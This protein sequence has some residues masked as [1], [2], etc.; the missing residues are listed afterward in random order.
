MKQNIFLNFTILSSWNRVPLL[1]RTILTGILVSGIGVSIWSAVLLLVLPP[2]SLLIML[3]PLWFYWEYFSGIRWQKDTS[4]TRHAQFRLLKLSPR[5]WKWSLTGAVFFV[6]IVQSS[7]ILTFKL[8]SFPYDKFTSE[9]KILETLPISIAWLVIIMSSVV[10][11]ICE[12]TGFRGYMQVPLEKRYSPF[13]AITIVSLLFTL[14]HLNHA[15]A[16]PIIPNIFFASVLLGILAWKTGSLIPGMI[17][18]SI[19]DVFDYSFWWSN[20][21]GNFERKTIFETG[22]DK[23]FIIW[24]LI[25]SGT[26]IAFFMVMKK[27]KSI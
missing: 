3:I 21:A 26:V 15:W 12:E 17:A 7:F 27:I 2:W 1:I 4:E 23:S 14:I 19:L 16:A 5:V 24:C 11:G 20:L 25:F 18:H 22:M 9:Y 6:I 13:I 8:I 10:A